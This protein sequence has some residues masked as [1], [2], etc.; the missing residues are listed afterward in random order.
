MLRDEMTDFGYQKI[1]RSEKAE[2]VAEVFRSVADRYDVMN[3][4]MSLGL[5]RIWKYYASEMVAVRPG[6]QVL[7]LAGGT[8]DIAKLLAKKVGTQGVVTLADINEAMLARGRDR[9]INA[10]QNQ[11]IRFVQAN[12]ECLPFPDNSFNAVTIAFGLRNVTD[13]NAALR[14]MQRVLK[15]GGRVIILEF[16]KPVTIGLQEIYDIYSFSVLPRLGQWV[17]NDAESYQYLAESIRRHPDQI[18]LKNMME[19]SGFEDCSYQNLCGGIVA[20][21]KGYKY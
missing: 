14:E 3:D 20:I 1:P 15:P 16:S 2:R 13:K 5:H 7:D 4:L 8:G 11:N 18:T 6:W 10:G 12:A 17:A 21:H 9:L 19:K